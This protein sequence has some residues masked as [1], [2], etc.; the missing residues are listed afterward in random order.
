MNK[1]YH[2]KENKYFCMFPW[3]GYR[4]LH[5][6][7]SPC[8]CMW[9]KDSTFTDKNNLKV[10]DYKDMCNDDDFKLL[11]KSMI[12]EDFENNPISEYCKMCKKYSYANMKSPRDWSNHYFGEFF[13]EA[14]ENTN[15][16]FTLKNP[17]LLRF[18]HISFGNVCNFKCKICEPQRS[19][20]W[21][22]DWKSMYGESIDINFYNISHEDKQKHFE[23]IK[24]ELKHTKL[25][26][27]SS[28]GEPFLTFDHIQ[29]LNHLI[30]NDKTDVHL[31][32]NTNMSLRF[33]KTYDIYKLLSKFKKVI[34][35]MSIDGAFEYN[36]ILRGYD[37]N[38]TWE[39]IENNIQ[40]MI[41]EIPNVELHLYSAVGILNS[42]NITK[43]HKY[44]YDKGYIK[45][46]RMRV[47]PIFIDN[48][49]IQ[50]LPN[51]MKKLVQ[52]NFEEHINWLS[53]ITDE[54]DVY[55]FYH[56]KVIN[57]YNNFIKY[58]WKDDKS[59][60]L[61]RLIKETDKLDVLRNEKTFD[62]IE[63]LKELRNYS[64]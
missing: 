64:V 45:A 41:K 6:Y 23:T 40:S 44:F 57:E 51:E 54:E 39:V 24:E 49:S 22:P 48:Y 8:P 52:Q 3:I 35:L 27:F 4:N 31:L 58:M 33:Y 53:T 30:E 9:R 46:N 18:I 11:R 28:A 50:V 25:I 1:E 29:I 42:F 5:G 2:L 21:I 36:K 10:R 59:H 43:L 56:D 17:N 13:D 60:Q 19:T 61:K 37:K 38:T 12:T 7:Y 47:N 32:Y 20:A 34:I 55:N 16:D 62:V 14:I 15:E 63:E 26:H